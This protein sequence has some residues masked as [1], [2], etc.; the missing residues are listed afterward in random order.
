MSNK[1]ETL[2][3]D[4]LLDVTPLTDAEMRAATEYL[5]EKRQAVAKKQGREASAAAG[6]A[7]AGLELVRD[8]PSGR[9]TDMRPMGR[10]KKPTEY[11]YIIYDNKKKSWRQALDPFGE[12]GGPY[13]RVRNVTSNPVFRHQMSGEDEDNWVNIYL[14][15]YNTA[16]PAAARMRR[17]GREANTR[18]AETHAQVLAQHAAKAAE[19]AAVGEDPIKA[20]TAAAAAE[21]KRRGLTPAQITEMVDRARE[22]ARREHPVW[23]A[24]QNAAAAEKVR[25]HAEAQAR[26]AET[27][28]QEAQRSR[29]IVH[30]KGG[31]RKTRKTR[32]NRK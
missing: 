2:W 18:R 16:H 21:G 23:A 10:I 20:A 7:A 26:K 25:L 17:E 27:A 5:A 3:G 6:G 29:K 32:K 14:K 22:H 19:K 28:K 15:P 30:K 1:K 9:Y 4:E 31:A 24:R 12:F 8:D 11:D 13:G